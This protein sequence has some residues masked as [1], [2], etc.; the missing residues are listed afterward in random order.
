M[1]IFYLSKNPVEAAQMSCDKHVVKM[2]LESAQLLSTCHRVLDGIEYYDKT[3][4]G[5]KIKRWKHPNKNMETVL[6]KAGWIK[7]PSTLWL[8]ESAYNYLWLYQ[9][10]MALNEE[11]K[12]R[13]E[14]TKDHLAIQKL[15]DLLKHPPKNSKIN[16]ISTD[17]K[18]AMPEECKVPGDS[19]QS[20]RRYYIMKKR[21]FATWKSPSVMPDWY[22]KGLLNED[23]K[24][25]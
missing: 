10:M 20:Y 14:H 2:I 16:K 4:N 15:G 9:H 11:Y 17:P 3:K 25:I 24:E 6:Y 23:Y 13:Y 18:P 22:K 21:R 7:H 19:V 5:R 1:N 12:K 8:L